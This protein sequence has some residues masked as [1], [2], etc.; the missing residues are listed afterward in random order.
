[1]E[2]DRLIIFLK[3]PRPG[4]VK[5]RL[6]Q[7]MGNAAA[8][9]AYEQLVEH[10]LGRL[11]GLKPVTLQFAP[12]DAGTEISRWQKPGWA[13]HPQGSGDLG[14][15]LT[16]A[17]DAAFSSGARRVV[18]I[19]SDCPEV[20]PE[21]VCEAWEQLSEHDVVLG[22]AR[23]GGYWLVALCA[24]RPE[25]FAGIPWSTETVLARTLDRARSLGL[26]A[27]LL[28]ELSDVDTETE[29]RAFQ[30]RLQRASAGTVQDSA[31]TS[32]SPA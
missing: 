32:G 15:R 13:L 25:L 12:D 3:A 22:P 9:A 5:T 17:F 16:R 8:L 30:D 23:D 18:V 14:L 10:L 11:A 29:W 28:R 21:D 24:A 4:A 31:A 1:M 20:T 26:R 27:R 19:G 2:P 7:T 6:A